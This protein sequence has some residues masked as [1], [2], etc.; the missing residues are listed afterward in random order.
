MKKIKY[1]STFSGIGGSELGIENAATELGMTTECVGFSGV[2]KFVI[3]AYQ[4]DFRKSYRPSTTWA[5]MPNGECLTR[6][7][8]EACNTVRELSLSDFFEENV[9]PKYYLSEE[10]TTKL[11]S[12]LNV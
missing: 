4:E 3:S 9:N 1:F 8:S 5:T 12:L 2:D 10:K 7:T 11:F 6:S